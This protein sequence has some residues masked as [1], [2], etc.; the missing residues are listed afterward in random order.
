MEIQDSHGKRFRT[1]SPRWRI[2]WIYLRVAG[3]HLYRGVWALFRK[4]PDPR[5][6]PE[7]PNEGEGS[8]PSQLCRCTCGSTAPPEEH[9]PGCEW[10]A[11]MCRT[12]SGSGHCPLCLGDGTKGERVPP[13]NEKEMLDATA[14]W[15]SL[16][17]P[18]HEFLGLTEKQYAEYVENP[19][20]FWEK[21]RPVRVL[22]GTDTE[23]E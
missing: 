16:G 15:H 14:R 3:Q 22:A 23:G 4:P 8:H 13:M 20:A 19:D 9:E 18:I 1:F 10:L 21:N 5:P 2:S 17:G 6:L 11:A 7:P 12:C